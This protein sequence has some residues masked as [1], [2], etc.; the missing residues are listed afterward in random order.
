MDDDHELP[1]QDTTFI[2][3]NHVLDVEIGVSA[4][5]S[6]Q[7]GQRFV[8]DIAEPVASLEVNLVADVDVEG[9]EEIRDGQELTVVRDQG[10]AN[11][12]S[13]GRGKRELKVGSLNCLS[14]TFI[15]GVRWENAKLE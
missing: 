7:Q 12:G 10:R 6:L 9:A 15:Q 4:A 8:N 1:I 11:P 14:D 3:W 5:G 13:C 2:R